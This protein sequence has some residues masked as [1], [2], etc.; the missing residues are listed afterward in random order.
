[1]SSKSVKSKSPPF[2]IPSNTKI[3][4]SHV[5]VSMFSLILSIAINWSMI[6]WIDK[7]DKIKCEC[8]KDWKKPMLKYWAYFAMFTT[9]VSFVINLFYFFTSGQKPLTNMYV[10]GFLIM[11]SFLNVIGTLLY[12]YNLK[13]IDCQCSED[14]RRE[15]HYIYNWVRLVFFILMLLSFVLVGIAF[16]KYKK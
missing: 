13:S 5:V 1:M 3:G 10:S 6:S 4:M 14:M 12:I 2:S 7:L 11:F 8:S 9:M 16:M 15:I